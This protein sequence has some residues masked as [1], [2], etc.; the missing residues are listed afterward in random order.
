MSSAGFEE[1]AA[2][3]GVRFNGYFLFQFIDSRKE[4]AA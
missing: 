1:R 2:C 4:L 3:I